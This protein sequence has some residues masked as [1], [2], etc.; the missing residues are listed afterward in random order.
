MQSVIN[1]G[2]IIFCIGFIPVLKLKFILQMIFTA[3]KENFPPLL[4][5]ADLIW[6]INEPRHTK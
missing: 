4:S 6:F 3:T 5:I 2:E 1:K